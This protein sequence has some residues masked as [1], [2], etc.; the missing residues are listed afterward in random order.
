MAKA[1]R[2]LLVGTACALVH[3]RK[4]GTVQLPTA[5]AQRTREGPHPQALIGLERPTPSP[6]E[7]IPL[8]EEGPAPK[9]FAALLLGLIALSFAISVHWFNEARRSKAFAF[10]SGDRRGAPRL[11]CCSRRGWKTVKVWMPTMWTRRTVAD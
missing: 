1:M 11:R 10:R 7:Q 9:D 6:P 2:L 4:L 5:L 3:N 8:V